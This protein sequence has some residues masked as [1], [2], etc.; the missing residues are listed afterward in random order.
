MIPFF[1]IL[2]AATIA[3]YLGMWA[4]RCHERRVNQHYRIPRPG[5]EA[6]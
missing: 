1:D 2:A 5:D 6:F 4:G 3:F